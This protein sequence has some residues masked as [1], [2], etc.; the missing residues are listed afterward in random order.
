MKV[1]TILICLLF[2]STCEK[3]A[4]QQNASVDLENTEV[5]Q[6]SRITK[7]EVEAIKYLD[8]GLSSATKKAVDRWIN[9]AELE[10]I[11]ESIKNGDLSYFKGDE[12]VISTFMKELKSDVPAKIKSQSIAARIIALETK[13]LKLK[14]AVQINNTPKA[15]LLSTIKEFLQACS[16]LNLQM[17][18]KLEKEF[19]LM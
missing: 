17:N 11:I 19:C 4:S 2:F 1:F 5:K 9:Y 12:K 10:S 15:E 13:F 8:Y 16:N 14:S 6:V 18:K 7:K 3:E